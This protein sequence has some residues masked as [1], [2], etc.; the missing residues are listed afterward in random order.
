MRAEID[1]RVLAQ[2]VQLV[3][4]NHTEKGKD[5]GYKPVPGVFVDFDGNELTVEDLE[6]ISTNNKLELK[7]I[8][9]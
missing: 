2:K 3:E 4:W 7:I 5:S 1:G 8:Y 9:E 6:R